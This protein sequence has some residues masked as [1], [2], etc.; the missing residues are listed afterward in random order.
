MT[1]IPKADI[2]AKPIYISSKGWR[3]QKEK[4]ISGAEGE[5]RMRKY[6]WR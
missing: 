2:E 1:Q 6:A 5:T 4:L 3:K